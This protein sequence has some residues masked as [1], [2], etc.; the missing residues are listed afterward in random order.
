MF[1]NTLFEIPDFVFVNNRNL[2]YLEIGMNRIERLSANSFSGSAIEF[3]DISSNYLTSYEPAWF[4]SINSTLHTLDL[5]FNSISQVPPDAFR[6][7]RGLNTLVLNANPLNNLPPN[8]FEGSDNLEFLFMSNC[9]LSMLNSQWFRTLRSLTF[10]QI[11][12]NGFTILPSGIFNSLTSLRT[13]QMSN[14]F[15]WELNSQIFGNSIASITAIDAS[16]NIVNLIDSSFITSATSLDILQL[17]G[18]VCSDQNFAD[19]ANYLW[20][21]LEYL[22]ECTSNFVLEEQLSCS[23][24]DIT[25]TQYTCTLTAFNPRGFDG[26]GQVDGNHLQGKTHFIR[27]FFLVCSKIDSQF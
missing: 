20:V 4:A 3:L 27:G 26:F 10:L 9:S 21:T 16:N 11:N 24:G 7:L 1:D 25:P 5:I 6:Q 22:S 13:L 23:Y 19:V 18:N 12:N 15:I 2:R 14:N 8:V 17:N